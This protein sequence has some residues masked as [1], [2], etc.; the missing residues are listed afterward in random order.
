M[1]GIEHDRQIKGKDRSNLKI[2]R[3]SLN[4]EGELRYLKTRQY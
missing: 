4:P 1:T 3:R 2:Y